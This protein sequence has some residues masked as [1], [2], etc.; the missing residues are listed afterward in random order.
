VTPLD[1]NQS[2][3]CRS[4]EKKQIRLQ[5]NLKM[6]SNITDCKGKKE[7]SG[8]FRKRVSVF[9]KWARESKSAFMFQRFVFF[10]CRWDRPI[11]GYGIL[12]GGMLGRLW[13]E[14]RGVEST[15]CFGNGRDYGDVTGMRRARLRGCIFWPVKML[16]TEFSL[17]VNLI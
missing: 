4:I 5:E 13:F 10:F 6:V 17:M 2:L 9:L 3:G 15:C 14:G 11:R 16:T 1:W 8:E 7:R 12:M